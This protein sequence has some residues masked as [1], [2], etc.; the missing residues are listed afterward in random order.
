MFSVIVCMTMLTG[1]MMMAPESAK[2]FPDDAW[3]V[4][5][6]SDGTNPVEKAYV[7]AMLFMANGVEINSTETD[8][9]GN[10]LMMVPGGL[11]YVVFAAHADY[12]ML[13]NSV[14]ISP[15]ET[16][17]CDFT[18][19][20]LDKTPDVTI[21]G[22]VSN[23]T[24]S[25]VSGGRVLA[26]VT[27]SSGDMPLYA[28]ITT[29]DSIT[30]YFEVKVIEGPYGGGAIGMDF[31]GYPMSENT[32]K[33]PLEKGMSYEFNITLRPQVFTDDA[34]V[35]GYVTNVSTGLPLASSVVSYEVN[36]GMERYSNWTLTDGF[37]YYEMGAH[38]GDNLRLTIQKIGYTIKFYEIDVLPTESVQ[39]DAALRYSDAKI[40]GY[41][42]EE[43]GDP[44]AFCRVFLV[45]NVS[46]QENIS[47][48]TT[49][50]AGHYVLDAFSGTGLYFGA[51][52]DGYARNFTT[53]DVN[54]DDS[55]LYDFTLVPYSSWLVGQ[56]TDALSGAPLMGASVYINGPVEEQQWT[57]MTGEYN[58]SLV[59]GDYYV[60]VNHWGG[61]T[62]YKT[63]Y[64]NITVPDDVEYVLDVALVP[65]QNALVKGHVYDLISGSPVP[66][67]NIWLEGW[68]GNGTTA[69]GAGDYELLNVDGD[70]TLHANADNYEGFSANLSLAELSVTV[71]DIGMMPMN[72]A[73]TSLLHGYVRNS[74]DLTPVIGAEVRI[75]LDNGTFEKFNTT[76]SSGY[77]ELNV[78][79]WVL[80]VRA[81][82]YQHAPNFTEIDLTGVP[83]Y[84]LDI[85]LD[86]DMYK[87]NLTHSQ[88]P[89]ENISWSNPSLIQA[90]V[91]EQNLREMTIMFFRELNSSG[92]NSNWSLWRYDRTSFDP[93]N[94]ENNLP[95]TI[96]DG[97]YSVNMMWQTW[98]LCG[99]LWNGT[100]QA[101]FPASSW[102]WY[103]GNPF[104][105]SGVYSNSTTP[106][107]IQGAGLFNSTT[108]Q[109]MAFWG[110][111]MTNPIE[112]FDASSIF[113]PLAFV[114]EFREFLPPQTNWTSLGAWD[115]AGL[116]FTS[117]TSYPS[118]N[119]I[120]E[121]YT[122]DWGGQG[123]AFLNYVT[124]D[125]DGPSANAGPDQTVLTVDTVTLDGSGSFDKV[126]IQTYAW[127]FNNATGVPT[128][129]Y[130]E[131]VTYQFELPGDYDIDL[132]V[133][134]GAGH[135]AT[136]SLIVHVYFDAPPVAN[137]GADQAV[138][139][140]TVV[141]FDGSGSS[142]DVDV[143]NFTWTI[144]EL[145][146]TMY[147]VGPQY[148][149]SV[150][151]TYHVSLIV[152][153]TVGQ[154]SDPDEMIVTVEDA[155]N[156]VAE[157]GPDQ[158]V[159]DG[160][161]VA[162]DG[163]GSTDNV[164]IVS[165]VW[166][167]F[168]VT[169]VELYGDKP[170]Y[171][172]SGLGSYLVT[173]NVSDAAGNW[174]IDTMT[175]DVIA[176]TPPVADAGP[177]QT[178]DEDTPVTFD[179]SNSTDDKGINNYTWEIIELSEFMYEANPTYTFSEP[180][181]YHVWLVVNDTINQF[182]DPDEM[183]VTVNDVTPPDAVAA[184]D[185]DQYVNNGTVVTLNGSYST[186]N[187]VI[188]DY[189]WTFF[190]VADIELHGMTVDY[191]FSGPGSYAVTLNVTDA[192]GNWDTDTIWIDVNGPPVA[193][194]SNSD[195]F[196]YAG[197]S[198]HFVG[199][200]YDDFDLAGDMSYTWR[201]VYGGSTVELTGIDQWY[202]FY[203]PG[204]YTIYLTVVDSLGLQGNSS[205][206][207]TVGMYWSAWWVN[208]VT[209]ETLAD[210]ATISHDYAILRGYVDPNEAVNVITPTEA[211]Q[212]YADD[213]GF[214]EVNPLNLS[215]GLNIVTVFS[216]NWD[217]G[218][219]LSFYK[220]I[221]SDTNCLL[222]VD[223]PESPTS[224]LTLAISGW[225][226]SDA[227][228]TVN[229]IAA[230][231][232]P[233]GTFS[234]NVALLEGLNVVNITATDSVGNMNWAELVVLRDTTPPYLVV[235]APS[236]GAEISEPN[237][238][239]YGTVDSGAV[240]R[241]NGVLAEDGT[242]WSATVSLVEGSNTIVVTA[243]DSVGNTATITVVV[244][245]V[246]PVYVTPEELAAVRAELLGEI[247]NLSAALQ[248]NVSALQDQ[249]DTAM[250]EIAALQTS[251]AENISA[252]QA[253]IDSAMDEILALQ[254]SLAENI[255]ALQV[256][257]DV[258]MDDIAA[259]QAS[260]A[261]NVTDLQDQIDTA[262]A[263]IAGLQASLLENVTA[264]Q[265]QIT[266]AMVDI[267]TLETAL[268]D[269]VTALQSQINSAVLDI[270]ALEAALA[271]NVTALESD[272]AALEAD[273]QANIT[274]LQ[275][276]IA[277]NA[278]ALQQA[279]AQNVTA[280]QSQIAALRSDLQANVT[281][282]T[283]AL[284]AN[285]TALEGLIDTLD[286]DVADVQAQL[287]GVNSTLM[288]AQNQTNQAIDSMQTDLA[289]LQQQ[290]ADLN[291]TA[292]DAKDKAKDTDSFASM[293]MYLTLILF[294]IAAIMV[295]LVWYLTS[296]KL[297]R[298]GAGPQADAIEE[299]E[300]PTEV[301][302]EFESL[303]KEIK[304]EEL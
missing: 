162:F 239:V 228:V 245:Y 216:Y 13:M 244:D 226:D 214:F 8:A 118:G 159:S 242:D 128:T 53:I 142:D 86:W 280:L 213:D 300:E 20:H 176:D 222:W 139:E 191:T 124:V 137:A 116:M 122:N 240:V 275:Q 76:D 9:D 265:T 289:D 93:W 171:T 276:A 15:G 22:Y 187:G 232:R 111:G 89:L 290:I 131:V 27:D 112:E 57:N 103:Q 82:A 43:G 179:G 25:P 67:A 24:G 293:L 115:V 250:D 163:S 282:L 59:P 50:S 150:P 46:M 107:G 37:G 99:L 28:N 6:V 14:T 153:D 185:P 16:K 169:P 157:A 291:Q 271:E 203:F 288:A 18:L 32:T 175:V 19:M 258:A 299:V 60:Q 287:A 200:A 182:S 3:I 230:T 225:T 132:T 223:S 140:D 51:E 178:V 304:D 64:D 34:V 136:D 273:L 234:A 268:T 123:D 259:L 164:G 121:F 47:M 192:G 264:L 266:A 173:L 243:T 110:Y 106:G 161:L 217:W 4:G 72:P 246:P 186:D 166:S 101:Y 219:I 160:T 77:Y 154:W 292:E 38:S 301:E 231:V 81:T 143:V 270:T 97:N 45:D 127:D 209:G 233:D 129:L 114:L 274:A 126:G 249:I 109:F 269:N 148:T 283:A 298:G 11:T 272:I 40:Q 39:Q 229:G 149:F 195:S 255:T 10:F 119:Y 21:S 108:G 26:M 29:P 286:Q 92:L 167:F 208:P 155:T 177:D 138:D 206:V 96:V 83:D 180:G 279:L 42:T 218:D 71:F 87:P 88:S 193:D 66:G 63:Y 41:V 158:V 256:Q 215:E 49:D 254:A 135:S 220:M 210:G 227:D 281:S 237:V 241:V 133:W 58:F 190:D 235:T 1:L 68:W 294:A 61:G 48:A 196:I 168:D 238:L 56:V 144:V 212:V 90:T 303:E 205:M 36:V 145:S 197:D 75:R 146:V 277:Q 221:S 224:D 79:P 297:G 55:L 104:A 247:N 204:E 35:H 30:G 70:Y 85:A 65:W 95:F 52:Q 251:L 54:P 98:G 31:P 156:P 295:G 141:T 78:P 100:E 152:N 248:E 62:G 5:N 174:A 134:D 189:N 80:K 165:Y 7:K 125:N 44:I 202:E 170:S 199:W 113:S 263:D 117:Q 262:M 257:I 33:A 198:A 91:E 183:V 207:L 284:A 120:T 267:V 296:K 236:D 17:T 73:T 12:Y 105:V 302:R 188:V 211:Y 74:S 285:V 172:F 201:F 94:P 194:P 84:S 278:T 102:M 184:V 260:V 261:E 147:E 252:L 2:A 151:G 130:G 23:E 253:Q 69:N 181:I